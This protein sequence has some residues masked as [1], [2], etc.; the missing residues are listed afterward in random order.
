[1][2]IV[3]KETAVV[4]TTV[5]VA[6]AIDVDVVTAINFAAVIDVD[7]VTA[8]TVAAVV[9]TCFNRADL[10]LLFAITDKI[11]DIIRLNT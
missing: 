7:V 10:A 4:A 1:M 2:C 11:D 9:A 6:A 5:G 8:I 3:F